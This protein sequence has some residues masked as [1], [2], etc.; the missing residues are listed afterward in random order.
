MQL[1]GGMGMADEL[2]VSHH[3]RRLTAMELTLG[4]TDHHLE[5]FVALGRELKR[6]SRQER[7]SRRR[8]D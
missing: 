2:D 7:G 4:D 1:H 3:F 5:S 6:L 8:Q